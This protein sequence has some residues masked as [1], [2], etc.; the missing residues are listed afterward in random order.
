MYKLII[1]TNPANPTSFARELYML[2]LINGNLT[3]RTDLT[4]PKEPFSLSN[5]VHYPCREHLR[6]SPLQHLTLGRRAPRGADSYCDLKS[7]SHL[8]FFHYTKYENA[9]TKPY[10][11]E[12]KATLLSICMCTLSA[13]SYRLKQKVCTQVSPVQTKMDWQRFP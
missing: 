9:P 10:G 13:D 6:K 3:A 5:K 1:Q 12:I 8:H 7:S 4:D 11:I 2:Q